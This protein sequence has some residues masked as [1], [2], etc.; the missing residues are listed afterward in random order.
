MKTITMQEKYN[1]ILFNIS[2]SIVLLGL[3]IYFYFYFPVGYIYLIAEDSWGEYSTFVSCGIGFLLMFVSIISDKE[4]LF[5][6]GFVLFALF[7]FAL[8][9]EEISWGERLF[10]IPIPDIIRQNNYQ[11]ELNLHNLEYLEWHTVLLQVGIIVWIAILPILAS[12]FSIVRKCIEKIGIPIVSIHLLPVFILSLYLYLGMSF[13]KAIMPLPKNDELGEMLIG[14]S[15]SFVALDIFKNSTRY[16]IIRQ[17]PVIKL[18]IILFIL[19]FS[20][21]TL[22]NIIKPSYRNL[23]YRID[24]FAVVTYPSKGLNQQAEI[25]FNYALA[26]PKVREKDTRL[27]YGIFLRNTGKEEKAEKILNGALE[28]QVV[29]INQDASNPEPF[30]LTGKIYQALSEEKLSIS[31]YR[32]AIEKYEQQIKANSNH[33]IQAKALISIC[34]IYYELEDYHSAYNAIKRGLELTPRN[35]YTIKVTSEWAEKVKA[36]L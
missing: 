19:I 25:L 9:M 33:D 13:P 20:C 24:E 27:K 15:L 17:G 23:R 18:E 26:E 16:R 11:G 34:A 30:F 32:L 8:A 6:I 22:L 10:R 2:L 29:L 5:K 28:E 12:Q 4:K 3:I 7:L 21:T 36:L 14:L 35:V 31:N 1:N